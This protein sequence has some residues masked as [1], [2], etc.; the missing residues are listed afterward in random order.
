MIQTS[1]AGLFGDETPAAAEEPIAIMRQLTAQPCKDC[2]LS[3][4]TPDNPGFL[5]KGNPDA[6]IA[7][8]GD[9]PTANDISA[10]RAFADD[11]GNELNG[12][13]ATAK[14]PEGDV[15]YTY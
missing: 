6:H 10:R 7:V 4:D 15:F 13:I 14:I 3:L 9:M 1:L 8:V 5:W 12:W 11:V 2:R